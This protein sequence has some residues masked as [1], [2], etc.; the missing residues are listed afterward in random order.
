[1]AGYIA[2]SGAKDTVISSVELSPLDQNKNVIVGIDVTPNTVGVQAAI[3][4]AKSVPIEVNYVNDGGSDFNRDRAI[5]TPA[6]VTITGET[7]AIDGI[8]SI[9]TRAVDA[10]E[11]MSTNAVPVQLNVPEGIHL[12][13]PD[14]SVILRYMKKNRPVARWKFRLST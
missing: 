14:E 5:L 11:L 12:V 9:S 7:D 1:M 4:K 13:N 10:K 3:S 6:T 2:V 8:E